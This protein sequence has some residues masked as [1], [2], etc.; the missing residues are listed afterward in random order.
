MRGIFTGLVNNDNPTDYPPV[1][2]ALYQSE[3]G[4]IIDRD[5]PLPFTQRPSAAQR[6]AKIELERQRQEIIFSASFKLTALQVQAGDNI[7]FSFDRYGWDS[8]V[9]EIIDWSL[10]I[11]GDDESP[12]P[13]VN[14]TLQEN[15]E[16]V[17]D[18]NDGEETTYDLA[19]QYKLA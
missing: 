19:P 5:L 4:E 11:E 17:Y 9:F 1:E 14:M 3:D 12:I 15:A 2:N 13:V 6:I 10:N 18:W 16:G 8:K 7:L